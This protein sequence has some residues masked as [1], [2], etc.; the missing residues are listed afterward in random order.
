MPGNACKTGRMIDLVRN[1]MYV[2]VCILLSPGFLACMAPRLGKS[3]RQSNHLEAFDQKR[4]KLSILAGHLDI[5]SIG[6]LLWLS[7]LQ[8][9][10]F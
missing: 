5:G 9:S 8:S 3:I 4:Q 2:E 1:Y 6:G 7:R 10:P